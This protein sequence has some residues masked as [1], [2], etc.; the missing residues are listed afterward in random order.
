[1]Y[2]YVCICIYILAKGHI[3]I[4]IYILAIVPHPPAATSLYTVAFVCVHKGLS[5]KSMEILTMKGVEISL[6]CCGILCTPFLMQL[7]FSLLFVCAGGAR[8][9]GGERGSVCMCM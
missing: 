6:R 3:Y 9:G 7:A 5:R 8:E 2:S 1:M 4:Y